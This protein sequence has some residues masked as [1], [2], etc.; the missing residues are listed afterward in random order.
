[1]VYAYVMWTNFVTHIRVCRVFW[2][3]WEGAVI[4]K[5]AFDQL[6]ELTPPVDESVDMLR[7]GEGI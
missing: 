3:V 2:K 4:V 1:M 6:T 5:N 7:L